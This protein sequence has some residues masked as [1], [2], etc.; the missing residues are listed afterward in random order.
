MAGTVAPKAEIHRDSTINCPPGTIEESNP[1]WLALATLL[2]ESIG[3]CNI[4]SDNGN[5]NG[6]GDGISRI[7]SEDSS[8]EKC[9]P[10]PGVTLSLQTTIICRVVV[11][12]L[13]ITRNML[14][15]RKS[16]L[17]EPRIREPGTVGISAI[18][19]SFSHSRKDR[20]QMQAT[21]A[22]EETCNFQV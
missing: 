11:L 12:S 16:K 1:F 19:A 6:D 3:V 21:F 15:T 7:K 9:K 20:I 4:P 10:T 8:L 22:V 5:G 2:V 13:N 17:L 14:Q 18:P